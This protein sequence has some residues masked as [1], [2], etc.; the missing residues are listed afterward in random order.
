MYVLDPL[1]QDT[2]TESDSGYNYDESL[3]ITAVTFKAIVCLLF[4]VILGLIIETVFRFLVPTREKRIYVLTFYILASLLTLSC[5]FANS[6]YVL[7]PGQFIS[8]FDF[9]VDGYKDMGL[10][11]DIDHA[12]LHLE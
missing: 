6:Y 3:V 5:L 10:V 4:L 9:M 12:F 8:H 7:N 2:S 11:G 1:A